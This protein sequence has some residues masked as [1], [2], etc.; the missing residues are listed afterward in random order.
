[1]EFRRLRTAPPP[2]RPSPVKGE[3]DELLLLSPR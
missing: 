3:G 1:L 2:P